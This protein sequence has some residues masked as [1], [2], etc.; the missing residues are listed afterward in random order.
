[1]LP[2]W[3]I[4]SLILASA[5][6]ELVQARSVGQV[7]AGEGKQRDLFDQLLH[8]LAGKYFPGGGDGTG[9]L[10]WTVHPLPRKRQ[11]NLSPSIFGGGS[12]EDSSGDATSVGGGGGGGGNA[13]PASILA[14]AS[15]AAN[16]ASPSAS[17][18]ASATGNTDRSSATASNT[19]ASSASSN[20][21]ASTSAAPTS[22]AVPLSKII[23]SNS[24]SSTSSPSTTSS[25]SSTSTASPTSTSSPSSSDQALLSPKNKF[26]PLVVTGL[27]AAG[28]VA[29][30][31]LIAIAR[32]LAHDQLRRDNLKKS[33]GFDD[34]SPKDRFTS[35][36][37][38]AARSIRR[39]LTK[40]KQLGSFARRTQDG[41]V[42]IEVGDEVFAVPPHLA[43]SYRER[44][45]REKRSRS[46]LSSES[47]GFGV[48]A[49]YL[50]DGGPDGDEE[51][52]RMK[53]DAMLDGEG[54]GVRRSLSQRLGDRLRSLTG[55]AAEPVEEKAAFSFA[56]QNQPRG[57]MRQS[58]L[59]ARQGALTQGAPGWSISQR[60]SSAG[61]TAP[62]QP[63][64]EFGTAKIM[65]RSSPPR[66]PALTPAAT[67]P[68][69]PLPA[70]TTQRT[71]ARKPPPKLELSLLTSKLAELERLPASSS[72]THSSRASANGTFG[73]PTLSTTSSSDHTSIPGAFPERTKSLYRSN[74]KP[75]DTV[76]TYRHR[77]SSAVRSKTHHN[78][79]STALGSPT[80][81]T[82]ETHRIPVNPEK[83]QPAKTSDKRPLPIPP[84]FSLP[85]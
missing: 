17:A 48:K 77:P 80:R 12:G 66:P 79:D 29:L 85:K 65:P 3:L 13:M 51:Q 20:P 11:L 43:D 67:A 14:A 75:S 38:G 44:I 25:S 39:A 61:Y 70:P 74:T 28:L 63:K 47:N 10:Q 76:G 62:K 82:H 36:P 37:I 72:L 71:K 8:N 59:T 55:G 54:G 49:K 50:S 18:S 69:H 58:D 27:A 42:L 31:M 16:T 52:A 68:S 2:K 78:R 34:S 23:T 5:G 83:P 30:M 41:S 60:Q 32:C 26:F 21:P 15:A 56:L 24:A 33:Y 40:K 46:D 35:A 53:Y 84:P 45:L 6:G 22:S 64:E 19:P 4:T 73:A 7:S 81:F 1:M 9:K 57:A